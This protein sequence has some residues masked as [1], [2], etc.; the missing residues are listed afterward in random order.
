[1]FWFSIALIGPAL[2]AATNLIDKYLLLRFGQTIGP[3]VILALSAVMSCSLVPL[4][5]AMGGNVA[6]P[7]WLTYLQIALIGILNFLVLV[8]YL[9]ALDE[10]EP[11]V[12]VVHYSLSAMFSAILGF[13]FLGEALGRSQVGG[14]ALI[15][16]GSLLVTGKAAASSFS[17][18][19]FRTTLLM[20][21]AS[22]S[23]AISA[24]MFKAFAL[25][26]S[27]WT[28]LLWENISLSVLGLCMLA[29]SRDTRRW[30]G[31]MISFRRSVF[32]LVV[33]NEGIY[34]AANVAMATAFLAGL[35]AIALLANAFQPFFV[36]VLGLLT[37]KF[38][39]AA[40][41]ER[42]DRKSIALKLLA[43]SVAG[44]GVYLVL[45]SNA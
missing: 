27:M 3:K 8:F 41:V 25:D 29:F 17:A 7:S 19:H 14:M 22:A 31:A 20:A 16:I 39:G 21:L 18:D 43:I 40:I 11:S 38:L 9:F 26:L 45:S 2:Y 13:L 33:A 36:L 4:C 30:L 32:A 12:V 37:Q 23:W 28:V 35:V 42:S 6:L 1:M 15:V 34:L 5:L 24:V 44:T 10:D